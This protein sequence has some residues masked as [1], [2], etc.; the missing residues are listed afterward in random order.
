MKVNG[1]STGIK[2]TSIEV[3]AGL[4]YDSAAHIGAT[5]YYN[6]F[7]LYNKSGYVTHAVVIGEDGSI[8]DKYVYLTS[9]ITAKYYDSDIKDYVYRYDAIINGE[10][11]EIKSLTALENDGRTNLVKDTLY[12]ASYDADG[13]VTEMDDVETGHTMNNTAA[14]KNDGYS[15]NAVASGAAAATL[16]LKGATLYLTAGNNTNYVILDEDCRFYVNGKDDTDGKYNEYANASA[17]LA[18]LGTDNAINGVGKIVVIADKDTG[19]ATSIIILDA[20]YTATGDVPNGA[21]AGYNVS[22]LT[23]APITVTGTTTGVN[24]KSVQIKDNAGNNKAFGDTATLTT[25]IKFFDRDGNW[26]TVATKEQT[27]NAIAA[28][29]DG[30]KCIVADNSTGVDVPAVLNPSTSYR[31]TMTLSNRTIGE[32]SVYDGIVTVGP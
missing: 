15:V 19:F 17:M 18:A 30:V 2:N 16:T 28:G 13:F 5:G 10:P 22:R 27:I 11:T 9:G 21:T 12:K 14:Y 7:A 29:S 8:A 26:V 24:L 25:V 1:I 3:K 32:L 6:V 23:A 4:Q 31:V 20:V